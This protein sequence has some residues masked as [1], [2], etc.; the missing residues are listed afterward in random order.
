MTDTARQQLIT[1]IARDVITQTAPHEW[2]LF[3]ASSEA[4][5]KN[6]EKFLNGEA[7]KVGSLAVAPQ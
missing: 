6:P 2:P 7:G 1:D 5:F 3:R 4:Y